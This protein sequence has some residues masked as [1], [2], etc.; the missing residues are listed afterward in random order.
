MLRAL[1]MKFSTVNELLQDVAR[2]PRKVLVQ[3]N[4]VQGTACLDESRPTDL[5][6]LVNES[7]R[8]SIMALLLF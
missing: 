5:E 4:N 1:G 6:V 7:V 2:I 3:N 8:Q